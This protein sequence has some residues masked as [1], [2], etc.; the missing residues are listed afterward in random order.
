MTVALSRDCAGSRRPAAIVP[1][2][3]GTNSDAPARNCFAADV[4]ERKETGQGIG[5]I[6][7]HRP[8][9]DAPCRRDRNHFDGTALQFRATPVA[10][11]FPYAPGLS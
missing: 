10:I 3:R 11:C 5:S 2:R 8:L 4:H 9:H 1:E 6:A 7:V